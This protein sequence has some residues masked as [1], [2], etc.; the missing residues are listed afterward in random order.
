M[1]ERFH[2][3]LKAKFPADPAEKTAYINRLE[4]IRDMLI[5]L[6]LK[7]SYDTILEQAMDDL[8]SVNEIISKDNVTASELQ[9]SLELVDMYVDIMDYADTTAM[10]SRLSE[11]FK[12]IMGNAAQYRNIIINKIEAIQKTTAETYG[13]DD[14]LKM[15]AGVS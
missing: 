1:Y 10:N 4:N 6:Q 5:V 8:Y 9:E 11:D 3:L 2:K 15:I 14:L 13:I 12:K 7:Q